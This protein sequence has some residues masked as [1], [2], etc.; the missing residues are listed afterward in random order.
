MNSSSVPRGAAFH[1][2]LLREIR[3]TKKE[4]ADRSPHTKVEGEPEVGNEEMTRIRRGYNSRRRG[5]TGKENPQ[6]PRVDQHAAINQRVACQRQ[7]RAAHSTE[8]VKTSEIDDALRVRE[9][10]KC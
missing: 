5:S 2:L 9:C 1:F 3:D 6:Y 8:R 10:R 7:D 4:Q